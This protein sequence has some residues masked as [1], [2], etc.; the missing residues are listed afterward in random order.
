MRRALD[1]IHKGCFYKVAAG[2][3]ALLARHKFLG[4]LEIN[5]KKVKNTIT[6]HIFHTIKWSTLK[7]IYILSN[8]STFHNIW[9]CHI[10]NMLSSTDRKQMSY[11]GDIGQGHVVNFFG[12]FL[13]GA[14]GSS[15]Q[16]LSAHVLQQTLWSL[17]RHQELPL[18][19]GPAEKTKTSYS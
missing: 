4:S 13:G 18:Q 10:F 2:C 16:S 17:Q 7:N 9:L 1:L 5:S 14:V 3:H 8:W 6:K 12:D 11:I 15:G 19:L